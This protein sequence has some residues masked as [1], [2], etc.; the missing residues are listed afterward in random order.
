MTDSRSTGR[1]PWDFAAD[2]LRQGFIKWGLATLF[3]A[4][5]AVVHI[6]AEPGSEISLFLGLV[7]YQKAKLVI[8][9]VQPARP[10][11]ATTSDYAL[12]SAKDFADSPIPILDGTINLGVPHVAQDG[13]YFI[14]GANIGQVALAARSPDGES[15]SPK[16]V[17]SRVLIGQRDTVL[18]LEYKGNYFAIQTE[19]QTGDEGS[20]IF[21]VKRVTSPTLQLKK[22]ADY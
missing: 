6:L 20:F 21:S 17:G 19:N 1:T 4:I 15:I 14:S 7:K 2:I 3:F 22:T 10:G 13:A 8:S 16:K 12:P 11:V 9:P 18:E 5:P